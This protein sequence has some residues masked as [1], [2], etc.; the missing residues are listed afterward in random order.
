MVDLQEV[1][2]AKGA[3]SSRAGKHAKGQEFAEV[4]AIG[5]VANPKHAKRVGAKKGNVQLPQQ[6]A[7]P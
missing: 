2:H 4:H 7:A 3:D 5:Q 1:R 6:Q